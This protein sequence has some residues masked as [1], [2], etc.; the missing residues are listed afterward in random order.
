MTTIE[1]VRG[2]LHATFREPLDRAWADAV[3][4]LDAVEP[5]LAERAV[6][7]IVAGD[8]PELPLRCAGPAAQMVGSALAL[9]QTWHA[10]MD[11][12]TW[13]N[14]FGFVARRARHRLYGRDDLTAEQ[15]L[16][17][18]RV[19]T[20]AAEGV[21]WQ[22]GPW[23]DHGVPRWL[24]A[25]LWDAFGVTA[26]TIQRRHVPEDRPAF[27]AELLQRMLTL[28][29]LDDPARRLA[30]AL[31]GAVPHRSPAPCGGL[32]ERLAATD[33]LVPVVAGQEA[34]VTTALTVDPA[35]ARAALVD[36]A[37]APEIVTTF[38]AQIV[39]GVG[40]SGKGVRER[41]MM[42]LT[43]LPEAQRLDL[44]ATQLLTAPK[45]RLAEIAAA[46]IALPGGRD[47]V[48]RVR[49]DATAPRAAVLAGVLADSEGLDDN[50]PPLTVP[51]MPPLPPVRL[52]DDLVA[53]VRRALDTSIENQTADIER[54]GSDPDSVFTSTEW[55]KQNLRTRA[56][57]VAALTL[58][59]DEDLEAIVS[60]R[61]GEEET[62]CTEALRSR[63]LHQVEKADQGVVDQTLRAVEG[64]IAGAIVDQ[65]TRLRWDR[66]TAR[67]GVTWVGG[68][69]LPPIDLRVSVALRLGADA[70]TEKRVHAVWEA[71]NR[72][73][74]DD[75]DPALV[76]PFFAENPAFLAEAFGRGTVARFD[77][78]VMQA[79]GMRVLATFPRVP[80]DYLGDLVL[81]ARGTSK[82]N[83]PV[84]QQLLSGHPQVRD[85]A[86]RGLRDGKAEVRAASARWVGELG[87]P[88]SVGALRAALA[89]EKREAVSAALLSALAR[90]GED[91]TPDLSP[92][93]LL[94]QAQAGLSRKPPAGLDWFPMDTLPQVHWAADGSPVPAEVL[95][96]W[97]VLACKLKDPGGGGLIGI[98]LDLLDP[99]DA[100]TLGEVVLRAWVAH[101]TR[102]PSDEWCRTEAAA[103]APGRLA[104]YQRW[105]D[106]EWGAR[107][108][109]ATLESV[110]KEIRAELAATY[111]GSATGEKGI[112]ALATAAP[113]TT[114]AAVGRAYF[115]EHHGRMSQ[116]ESLVRVAAASDDRVALQ[117]VLSVAQRSRA[118]SLQ[119]KTREL[120]DE[121]AD[122]RGWSP[123]ELADRTVPTAGFDDDGVLRLSYGERTFTARIT[124]RYTV[125]L[126]GEDGHVIKALPA[127]RVHED[128]AT[129]KVA[130]SALS[131]ARKEL[132]EV[133]TAQRIRL[134]EAMC[135]QRRWSGTEWSEHLLAHP[136]V[137]RLV[138]D[139]VW[140]E[141][142][143]D[144]ERLFRPSEGA[145][146]GIDDDEFTLD[147]TAEVRVAHRALVTADVAAAWRA[148][149]ADYRVR[150]LFEQ[151]SEVAPPTELPDPMRI[152]DRRGWLSDNYALRGVAAKRDLV[153]GEGGDGGWFT[154][155]HKRFDSLGVQVSVGFTGS[156]LPES[157][158]VT[159]AVTD[160]RFA[161]IAGRRTRPMPVAEVPPV[162][163]WEAYGDYRA[164]AEAG[165]FDPEWERTTRW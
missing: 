40:A 47:R 121:I 117:W 138:S 136:L 36:F 48:D 69:E 9:T 16:R 103:Q 124:P 144:T 17:W 87:D 141:R 35:R 13:G 165:A 63:I 84:A 43:Q 27:T 118:A 81:I 157:E 4:G 73:L 96:W 54:L 128:A 154:E 67:H 134:Y 3:I 106:R 23:S 2:R 90:L 24:S 57:T 56:Q 123:E 33:F 59:T 155:Y 97:V 93:V 70:T 163:R 142:V 80:D 32:T 161:R 44:L 127:P 133:V 152:D 74:I 102:H 52:P 83:R 6:R 62:S 135:G 91:I 148:H 129:V 105:A 143:G 65:P 14:D 116:M 99:T 86:E 113:G 5:G 37:E 19:L 29:G 53:Q 72:G 130:K 76:W 147:P 50:P 95:R 164:M 151:F 51:P 145:L 158:Q 126:S 156:M 112:L 25:L 111:L 31:C 64:L 139:L 66:A 137:G 92:R 42:L 98:Y 8:D 78:V 7:Y 119:A 107:F 120:V 94:A 77:P 21:Q 71:V 132:K 149:L 38:A 39:P 60:A 55:G 150:P 10:Q 88:A 153:R 75:L 110:T 34:A 30:L 22:P 79:Y 18:V 115:R 41:T 122:R 159:A 46:V 125:E 162:L 146:L 20:P 82:V 131:S 45:P 58:V 114:I 101:D 160:L 15:V 28:D 140:I 108:R 1:T 49:S 85:L 26:Q 109:G 89:T 104:N 12:S 100:V 11:T 68:A 61:L